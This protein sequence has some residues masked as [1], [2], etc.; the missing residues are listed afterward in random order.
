M[1][2]KIL[3]ASHKQTEM[4]KDTIYLP[5][6][7]GKALNSNKDFGYQADNEGINISL[8][9]PYYSELTAIYWGWKNLKADYI[10]LA[11]YRRHFCYKRKINDWSSILNTEEAQRLCD[12]Y[13]IILPKKRKLYIETVYS[14]YDHT[15]DG[16]QFDEA[17]KIVGALTPEYLPAFDKVMNGRSLHLFNMFI[18]KR[19]LFYQY[20]EWMFPI[21]EQLEKCYDFKNMDPFQARLIGRVSERL[22]DVWII[23]NN[24]FYKEID[25]IYFGKKNF[26][27][28]VLGFIMAKFFG[29]KYTKSF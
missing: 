20:C 3:V 22:L 23:K 18:M 14:H 19:E 1:D 4:P 10:G 25:Y 26:H 15:F 24:L 9:N 21:L 27:K 8:K 5:I 29:K 12:K 17:R 2:I 6:H 16:K 13:D 11:H 7:V 28:K